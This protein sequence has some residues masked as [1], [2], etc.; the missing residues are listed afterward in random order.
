MLLTAK[1]SSYI[2]GNY[3]TYIRGNLFN[4]INTF[5]QV[6]VDK[7]SVPSLINRN[8]NDISKATMGL[9]MALR[10]AIGAPASAVGGILKIALDNSDGGGSGDTSKFALLVG[11]GLGVMIIVLVIAFVL[12]IPKF[13]KMQTLLDDL[14]NNARENIS[15]IRIVRAF[16]AQDFHSERF[17]DKN[18]KTYKVS[19]FANCVISSGFPFIIAMMSFIILGIY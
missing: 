12:V 3:A 13:G 17:E 14:N 7:F 6:E 9:N 2:S 19:S 10:L 1:A 16:N 11:C 18:K 5:S 8:T 4:H 15:G